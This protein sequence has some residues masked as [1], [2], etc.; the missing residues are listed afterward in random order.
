MNG[1]NQFESL[2][3]QFFGVAAA[4]VIVA[5]GDDGAFDFLALELGQQVGLAQD[6]NAA[7]LLPGKLGIGVD[8]ADRVVPAGG[9]ETLPVSERQAATRW[10]IKSGGIRTL[11]SMKAIQP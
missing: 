1:I 2:A 6:G 7:D 5:N 4:G 8:E 9:A 3:G 10:P 11:L